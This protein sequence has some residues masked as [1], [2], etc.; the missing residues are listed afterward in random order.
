MLRK[1]LGD[2][3]MKQESRREGCVQ[4]VF[5]AELSVKP[6]DESADTRIFNKNRLS[7][8]FA[9]QGMGLESVPHLIICELRVSHL[10]STLRLSLVKALVTKL[11]ILRSFQPIIDR[12]TFSLF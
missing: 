12:D 4:R 2:W 8:C 5:R 9:V 1:S 3:S 10:L 11:S 7:S 6:E